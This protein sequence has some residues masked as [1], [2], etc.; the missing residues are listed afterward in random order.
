M[1]N[2][3]ERYVNEVTKRLPEKDREEVAKELNANI[4]DMLSDNADEDEI[5]SVL[6]ELGSP[7]SLADKY[8]KKP[9]YLISPA[10]YNDYIGVIKWVVP[11][12]GVVTLIIG[13]VTGAIGAIE[14]GMVNIT[15]FISQSISSGISMGLSAATQALLWTTVGFVI[16]ERTSIDMKSFEKDWKVEELS[17]VEPDKYRISL[18][19]SIAELVVTVLFSVLA[20]LLCTG[21]LPFAFMIQ[22]GDMQVQHLFSTSFLI[23]C[24]PAIIIISLFGIF[25]CAVKIK[26]RRWTPFVCGAVIASNL[27]SMGL[28]LYMI[29][30]PD[31]LSEE[32]VGF[33]RSNGWEELGLFQLT[34][35]GLNTV[36]SILLLIGIIVVISS[37]AGCGMALYKTLKARRISL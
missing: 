17:E 15:Y 34:G 1:S 31:I 22:S 23:S 20:I 19:D 5:K 7:S 8:L 4:Y 37:L 28:M 26:I 27:V 12:V 33:L 16:A 25:E 24:I 2:W 21:I 6:Y 10:I 18:S 11:L 35:I 30:R 14:N 29:M 3:I 36:D 32:F 13:M 9:R